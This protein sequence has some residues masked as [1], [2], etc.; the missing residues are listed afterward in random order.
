MF[1]INAEKIRLSEPAAAR[2]LLTR[3]IACTCTNQNINID[4]IYFIEPDFG[5]NV[6]G[7]IAA[8]FLGFNDV[9]TTLLDHKADV[10]IKDNDGYTALYWAALKEHTDTVMNLCA[11]PILLDRSNCPN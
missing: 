4:R 3:L 7:L 10:D 5:T 8:A 6:T 2:T 9:V 1:A 11:N